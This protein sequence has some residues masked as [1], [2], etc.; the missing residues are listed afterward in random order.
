MSVDAAGEF[1]AGVSATHANVAK[2]MDRVSSE[3]HVRPG[4]RDTHIPSQGSEERHTQQQTD[5]ASQLTGWRASSSRVEG[6]REYR[7]TSSWLPSRPRFRAARD[8]RAAVATAGGGTT[9][10]HLPTTFAIAGVVWIPDAGTR[11][12]APTANMAVRP[13]AFSARHFPN[14]WSA[15]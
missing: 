11:S 2:T 10:P 9:T 1:S 4:S 13:T 8:S 5:E 15:N 14:D 3:V 7:S 6:Q 12:R